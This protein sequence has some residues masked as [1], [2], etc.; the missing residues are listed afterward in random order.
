MADADPTPEV[1][2]AGLNPADADPVSDDD[3]AAEDAEDARIA[4][5]RLSRAKVE[6]TV[7]WASIKAELG[8]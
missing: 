3:D 2:V 1:G 5:E 8:L 4:R 6:G 7:S